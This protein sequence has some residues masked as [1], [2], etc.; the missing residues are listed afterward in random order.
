MRHVSVRIIRFYYL[1]NRTYLI[2]NGL[3]SPRKFVRAAVSETEAYYLYGDVEKQGAVEFS[4]R[5]LPSLHTKWEKY[6]LER[7]NM[8]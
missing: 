2:L 8:R 1:I 7:F 4:G 3:L 5:E 6:S